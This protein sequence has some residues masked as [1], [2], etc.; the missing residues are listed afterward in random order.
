[1]DPIE[2]FDRLFGHSAWEPVILWVVFIVAVIWLGIRMLIKIWKPLKRFVVT[3]NALSILPTF[4]PETKAMLERL[5]SQ[6]E[7]DHR[8]NLRE[9][10]T[11]ALE[12]TRDLKTS[13]DGIHGRLDRVETGVAGLY[14]KVDELEAADGEADGRLDR[15]EHTMPKREIGHLVAD[16]EEEPDE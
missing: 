6:V 4:V 14:G 3:I 9:E 13:V 12:A 10:L 1:M 15:I 5:R 2:W 16:A 11:E 8:T 7:N